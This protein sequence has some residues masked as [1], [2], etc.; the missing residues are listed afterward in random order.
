MTKEVNELPKGCTYIMTN[1]CLQGMVKLG[2]AEDVEAERQQLST[3]ALPYAYEVYAVYEADRAMTTRVY[4]LI[5][6]LNPNLRISKDR[7]FFR[8]SP[9]EAFTLLK[10]VAAICNT[11]D[12]VIKVAEAVKVDNI[13]PAAHQNCT[14][15][16]K[17]VNK[18][19]EPIDFFKCGI[20]AGATLAFTEDPSVT[21]TVVDSHSVNYNGEMTRLS[22][23]A[24][25]LKNAKYGVRGASFFTYNGERIDKLSKRTQLLA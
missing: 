20:P 18:R 4:K 5:D 15:K 24:K 19:S 2:Y 14:V 6:T 12:K 25:E 22:P 9:E 1:P 23:L 10:T 11:Q 17:R 3:E 13:Q 7:E 8:V 21:V 16:R